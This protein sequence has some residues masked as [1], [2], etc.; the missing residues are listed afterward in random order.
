MPVPVRILERK[1]RSL[2]LESQPDWGLFGCG[3]CF[4][5]LAFL[6]TFWAL[7]NGLTGLPITETC[8]LLMLDGVLVYLG[9]YALCLPLGTEQVL[10]LDRARH[11]LTLT[12]RGLRKPKVEVYSLRDVIK[13]H[14]NRVDD[15]TFDKH[16]L[17]FIF[18][19]GGAIQFPAGGGQPK[20]VEL[21][22]DVVTRFLGVER[23]DATQ[24]PFRRPV[25][26]RRQP[27]PKLTVQWEPSELEAPASS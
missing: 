17:L 27:K 1:A 3:I 22:V 15:G 10:T 16:A 5:L 12:T 8:Y 6:L 21:L 23:S 25:K 2:S 18:R 19:G 24:I 11:T 7:A 4:L 13:V 9:F 20:T 26:H 14:H